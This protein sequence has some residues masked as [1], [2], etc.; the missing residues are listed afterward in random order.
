MSTRE[1][2][3]E[4]V[5][6]GYASTANKK[7]GLMIQLYNFT[8]YNGFNQWFCVPEACKEEILTVALAAISDATRVIAGIEDPGYDNH[9]EEFS[10]IKSLYVCNSNTRVRSKTI[11]LE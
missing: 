11:P 4:V 8:H 7:T 3:C 1:Y 10:E 9:P 6:V 2:Y 5:T